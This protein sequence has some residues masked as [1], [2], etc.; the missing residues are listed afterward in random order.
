MRD[1]TG[2]EIGEWVDRRKHRL[3][4]RSKG[5]NVKTDIEVEIEE[6]EQH[7]GGASGAEETIGARLVDT[8]MMDE[9][10]DEEPEDEEESED[11]ETES[12][13]TALNQRLMRAAA[14][15]DQGVDVVMDPDFEEYLRRCAGEGRLEHDIVGT[16][17]ALRIMADQLTQ[18]N[19]RAS[20]SAVAAVMSATSPPSSTTASQSYP[21]AAPA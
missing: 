17:D 14:M 12:T 10:D 20:S 13:G 9:D 5:I 2:M 15:R 11:E 16:R 4:S 6:V 18:V 7:N 19:A 1:T 21:P 8:D 3:L